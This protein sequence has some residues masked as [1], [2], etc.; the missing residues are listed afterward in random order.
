M[1]NLV[2]RNI[3][4]LCRFYVCYFC[5]FKICERFFLLPRRVVDN[6]YPRCEVEDWYKGPI[7]EDADECNC[8]V[9]TCS[10]CT[11]TLCFCIIES[12][13]RLCP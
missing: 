7:F 1:S 9:H 5:N 11:G 3:K 2:D 4:G 13:S 12:I 8:C 10:N 6:T